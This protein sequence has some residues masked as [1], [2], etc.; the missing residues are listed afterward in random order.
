MRV[1]DRKNRRRIVAFD[2]ETHLIRP[3]LLA[4]PLVCA[5]I[6]EAGKPTRLL[7]RD[8]A[9]A[10][11]GELLDDPEASIGGTN[12][13]FDLGVLCA[14][15]PSLL[16]RVFTALE[17][18]RLL[19][20]AILEALHENARG[21][22]YLDDRGV[23]VSRYSQALLEMRYG[24]VDRSAEKE[25]ADAWRLR[26]AELDGVP[27]EKWPTEA[28]EYPK[29]DAEGALRILQAQLAP[30]RFNVHVIG[31]EMRAAFTLHLMSVWGIRT[32]DERAARLI[33]EWERAHVTTRLR[34]VDLGLVRI[35][36]C[37]LED[38][39]PALAHRA[40][41]GRGAKFTA[42]TAAI[43]ALVSA[44]Y[45]KAAPLT[46]TGKISTST[47]TLAESGDETLEAYAEA[48][49]EEKLLSSFAPVLRAARGAAVN[50]S[51]KTPVASQRTSCAKP[52]LQQLPKTGGV[53]ECFVARR[54]ALLCSVDYNQ[55]EL[56]TLAQVCLEAFGPGSSMMADAI[57]AG[58]DLHTYLAASFA[59]V[60]YE[61][62][63]RRVK[64]G[65]AGAKGLR[66][67]AKPVNFGVPGLMGPPKIALTARKQGIRFCE[68]A[69]KA[70]RCGEHG[71][72]T[73]WKGRTIPPTCSACLDLAIEFHRMYFDAYP[74]VRDYHEL[75]I[76]LA[77]RCDK[78]DR[79][80]P[81]ESMGTGMLRLEKS[82]NA[83]SN[84]FFQNLAAQGAKHALWMLS[85]EAHTDPSSVLF[86]A[87]HPVAFIHDE[88]VAEVREDVAHEVAERMTAVML[89]AMREY[90]PD[91]RVGAEPCLM[92]RWY[93]DAKLVR[94]PDGRLA[95]WEPSAAE[96]K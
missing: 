65:E 58:K 37:K 38:G 1:D 92:R 35:D 46:D 3:G 39:E 45:G 72:E 95:P 87:C 64:A 68:L 88:I 6:A 34:F 91:V 2:T 21:R 61:E 66:T 89:E 80:E 42:N 29:R 76:D 13:C 84:H 74:E 85:R 86:G 70:T 50:A 25:G 28:V 79:S 30:E 19:D 11:F 73:S 36:P 75:T 52:N 18:E 26:Y 63:V 48:A 20:T 10:A 8:D 62:M 69:G 49:E 22:M 55:L 23:P 32:D 16:P 47:D 43:R 77:R 94:G 96:K 59:A 56:C 9:L 78:G 51:F 60:S 15:D 17:D 4:P 5:S 7:L 54:G 14:A 24:G 93:K 31:Q 90:V 67:C 40:K 57:N 44:A 33:E 27:L 41:P 53:R 82:A 12:F 71:R 83:V 81:I